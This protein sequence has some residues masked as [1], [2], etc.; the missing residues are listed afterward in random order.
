MTKYNLLKVLGVLYL[1]SKVSEL[2][3]TLMSSNSIR[4]KTVTDF[5]LVVI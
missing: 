5:N 4:M 1:R 2:F 3:E